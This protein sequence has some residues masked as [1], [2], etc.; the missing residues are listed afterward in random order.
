[1]PRVAEIREKALG[2][3]KL[4]AAEQWRKLVSHIQGSSRTE[5]LDPITKKIVGF[6]GGLRVLGSKPS[7]ELH[8]WT[9][10]R[11]M[12]LYEELAASRE[13]Q[14]LLAGGCAGRLGSMNGSGQAAERLV[15]DVSRKLGTEG[16]E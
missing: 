15:D 16:E 8:T 12:E 4:L 2:P 3:T 5:P 14:E 7:E 6:L 1:M 9:T 11:F 13:G 10:K